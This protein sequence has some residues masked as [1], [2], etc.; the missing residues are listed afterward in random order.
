VTLHPEHRADEAYRR[1]DEAF[2][3]ALANIVVVL[4]RVADGTA[5]TDDL[6]AA[7]AARRRAADVLADAYRTR[8]R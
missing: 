1:A 4:G 2:R 7:V 6:E 5:T 3:L 8:T